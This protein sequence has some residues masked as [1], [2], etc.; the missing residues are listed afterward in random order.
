MHR[1]ERVR[2]S[3]EPRELIKPNHWKE[4]NQI[5][6]IRLSGNKIVIEIIAR[7]FVNHQRKKRKYQRENGN[8][9]H[10][11]SLVAIQK[12]G[13]IGRQLEQT[14]A[15]RFPVVSAYFRPL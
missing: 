14:A 4:C 8:V 7:R 11:C 3:F 5:L 12:T 13:S 1:T 10:K 6:V 15:V 2:G 9:T